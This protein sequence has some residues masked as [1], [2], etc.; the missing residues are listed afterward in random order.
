MTVTPDPD[1]IAIPALLRAARGSYGLSIRLRLEEAGFEDVPRNGA[2]VLGGMTNQGATA[3]ELV[4]ELGVT[5]QAASLLIDTLVMRGYLQRSID[6]DDRR[7]QTIALTERGR[8]AAGVIRAG[9]IAVDE[10]LRSRVTPAGVAALR[11][12]L[13]ALIDIR[14]RMEDEV[15]SGADA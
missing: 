12:G 15:R 10:E 9:V 6:A 14:E 1:A 8:A 13:V 2:Y 5:K 4:R 7:R 11:T 3:G